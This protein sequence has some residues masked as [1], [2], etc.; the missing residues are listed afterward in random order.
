[1]RDTVA[2]R[3]G[4]PLEDIGVSQNWG[5]L[6]GG[7]HNKDYNLLGSILG[8]PFLGNYQMTSQTDC[9]GPAHLASKRTC[10]KAV[11]NSAF[12]GQAL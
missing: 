10:I 4:K 8:S 11:V 7:P 6:F 2:T 12:V 3:A 5:Y 1:M 9:S